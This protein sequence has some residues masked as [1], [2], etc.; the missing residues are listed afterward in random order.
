MEAATTLFR[1]NVRTRGDRVWVDALEVDDECAVRLVHDRERAGEDPTKLIVDAIEIGV[2]VLDREQAGANAE[3]VRAEFERAARE[4]ET[5]F[6]ARA[7]KVAERLDQ[8]VDEAFGADDGQVA[9]VLA[10]HFG[11]DSTSA[12]QNQVRS[13]VGEVMTQSRADLVRQFSS[14]DA[15]N[16]LSDFK[17]MAQSMMRQ[18]A[19]RQAEQLT[20]MTT[21]IDEMR[22]EI[23]G[24]RAERQKLEEVAAERDKGTAKG[25]TFEEQ[26]H[27]AVDRLAL[28]QGDGCD[29]VGDLLEGTR[30]TGDIVVG[31]GAACGPAR[32]RIVFEAK[33]SRLSQPKALEELDRA[34]RVRSA[35]YAILVVPS[36]ADVP[37][38]MTPLREYNG[39][40]LVVA[41]DP[42][43]P[44]ELPG[45][46]AQLA[47][48]V[49]YSLARARV[50]MART[51]EA[52][53]R[54]DFA[55][56]KETCERAV[57]AMEEVRRIKQQ[58]TG[59][60]TQIDKA[61][62]IVEAMASRVRAHIAE[63]DGLIDGGAGRAQTALL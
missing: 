34:L 31:V 18:A 54:V 25:R 38:R 1:S 26:V 13:I 15:S 43:P 50:L 42:P 56:V 28:A 51:G 55:A 2:R 21:R 48:Q 20:A 8:K 24:L 30:R 47:L 19:D 37:A 52:T 49:G 32:G 29:A 44:G 46:G 14:A 7:R 17:S 59:A 6:I 4:L 22:L 62:E 35:D 3:F 33:S 12:V 10:R 63:I 40:K 39:D 45:S 60:R 53:E 5:E 58:L 27:D 57:A 41:L 9:K 16:P 11:E 36:E 23:G 61:G